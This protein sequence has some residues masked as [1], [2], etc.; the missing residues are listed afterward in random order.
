MIWN[1]FRRPKPAPIAVPS[2]DLRKFDELSWREVAALPK[3]LRRTVQEDR[4]ARVTARIR[5]EIDLG[6]V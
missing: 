1:L 6:L 3:R 5:R 2:I 4:K